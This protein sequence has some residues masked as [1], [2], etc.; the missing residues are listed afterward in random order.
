MTNKVNYFELIDL[1]FKKVEVNDRVHFKQFGYPYFFLAYGEE[2]DQVT[3]EW[4]PVDREVNLYL[5]S[6]T[7]QKGLSLDEVK[8]I[9]KML[10]EKF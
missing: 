7:Y 2:D 8:N 9:V 5:N 3:M 1:G 6:R 10:E 4:S